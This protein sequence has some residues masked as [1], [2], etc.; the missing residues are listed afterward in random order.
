MYN[1]GAQ[2]VAIEAAVTFDT[3]GPMLGFTHTAGN[4]G[5]VVTNSGTYRL[6]FSVSGVQPSE[7]AVFVNGAALPSS[8]YGSG[9]GTQQDNGQLIVTLSANDVLTLVNHSSAAGVSLE[10]LAG[11]TQVNVNASVVIDQVG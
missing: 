11:G 3:N 7:F 6:T 1:T 5:I 8:I 10:T 9:A 4:A 2:T